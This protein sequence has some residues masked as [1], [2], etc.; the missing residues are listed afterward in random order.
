MA[1]STYPDLQGKV[2][3]VT[4]ASSGMGHNLSILLA[5]QGASVGLLDV[6]KPDK[7]AAEIESLAGDARAL[8]LAVD[9]TKADQMEAAVKA[10]FD[11]FGRLDGAANMAGIV[12]DKKLGDTSYA[13]EKLQDSDWDKIMKVNLDGVKNSLRAELK[14]MKGPGAIVNAASISGQAGNPFAVPYSVSKWGVIGLTKGAAG[15]VGS[16]GIRI[17]AVAPGIVRTPL[18][19]TLGQDTME[20]LLSSR[21]ALGKLADPQEITRVIVFMLSDAAAYMTGTVVNADGG[22]M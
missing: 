10:V 12:G 16:K 22:F 14:V 2:F 4:G 18:T 20:G 21:L 5:K 7:V 13:L 8:A 19:E 11:K 6:N 17:N 3:V 9:V 15:E 1:A